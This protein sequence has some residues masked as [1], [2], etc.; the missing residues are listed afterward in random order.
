MASLVQELSIISPDP[1]NVM[2]P[3]AKT[4]LKVPTPPEPKT[5]LL[6]TKISHIKTD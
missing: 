3:K 6:Q 2:A 5:L 4:E 1:K